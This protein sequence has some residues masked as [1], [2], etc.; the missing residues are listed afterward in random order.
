VTPQEYAELRRRRAEGKPAIAP[1]KCANCG[2][3][4]TLA[5]GNLCG[6]CRLLR[7]IADPRLAAELE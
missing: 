6:V 5:G 2:A 7:A 3:P 4:R 1:R